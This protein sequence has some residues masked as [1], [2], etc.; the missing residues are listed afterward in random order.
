MD[1]DLLKRR[2]EDA[3]KLR[4]NPF[5]REMFQNVKDMLRDKRLSCNTAKHPDEAADILRCEQLLEGLEREITMAV[6]RGNM[7]RMR[8]KEIEK[9]PVQRVFRR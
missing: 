2:G 1:S 6:K 9:T 8:I 3:Q 4:D 5:F 7:A